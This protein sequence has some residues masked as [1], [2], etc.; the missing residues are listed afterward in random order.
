M[1]SSGES[2]HWSQKAACSGLGHLFFPTTELEDGENIDDIRSEPG[3]WARIRQAREICNS[4]PVLTE[5][6]EDVIA[7]E[8]WTDSKPFGFCGGMTESERTKKIREI[9]KQF[10]TPS[11]IERSNNDSA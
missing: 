1:F 9:R 8:F 7:Y 5:C 11:F 3:K 4:C 2:K 6:A 10:G